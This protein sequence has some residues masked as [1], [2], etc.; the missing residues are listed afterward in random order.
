MLGIILLDGWTVSSPLTRVLTVVTQSLS[1]VSCTTTR[2]TDLIQLGHGLLWRSREA[3]G[4]EAR[5]KVELYRMSGWVLTTLLSLTF[6]ISRT[7]RI[8]SPPLALHLYLTASS[9]SRSSSRL[10]FTWWISSLLPI[11]CFLTAGQARCSPSYRSLTRDGYLPDVSSS[12][13]YYSSI[14]G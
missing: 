6:S 8:S 11:F 10:P 7:F 2:A 12:P 9:T 4:R 14:G 5:A 13:G 1:T 3:G